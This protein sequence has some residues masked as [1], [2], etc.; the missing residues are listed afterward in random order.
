MIHQEIFDLI[1]RERY[2]QDAL[3]AMGKF[4]F[5]CADTPGLTTGQKLGV[6][7]E[8]VGEVARAA[9]RADRL[10]T[11]GSEHLKTELIQVAAVCLAW[12]ESL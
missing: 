2:R 7:M 8:E 5:T 9:L 11:D 3:K 4:P 12:L 10:V 6:L 1:S